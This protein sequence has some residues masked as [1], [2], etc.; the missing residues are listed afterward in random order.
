MLVLIDKYKGH[1]HCV[2]M[3]SAYIGN[4]MAQIGCNE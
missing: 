4:I 2:M 3:D 1:G